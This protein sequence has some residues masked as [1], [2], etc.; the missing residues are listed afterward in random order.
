MYPEP[1]DLWPSKCSLG[2][3]LHAVT[4]S[5]RNA[6]RDL[7]DPPPR[8]PVH[9][10]SA[11]IGVALDCVQLGNEHATRHVHGPVHAT[12]QW[13]RGTGRPLAVR[14]ERPREAARGGRRAGRM[15]PIRRAQREERSGPRG[16]EFKFEPGTAHLARCIC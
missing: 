14:K 6:W 5:D 15:R 12:L 16:S 9:R 10:R 8:W 11:E 2:N 7:A 1:L 4:C 3:R 13:L